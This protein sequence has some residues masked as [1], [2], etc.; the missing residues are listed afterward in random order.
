MGNIKKNTLTEI[1]NGP[2][3]SKVREGFLKNNPTD[4]CKSCIEN[5][6]SELYKS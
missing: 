6:Q 3:M 4:V 1:W 5:S 2:K